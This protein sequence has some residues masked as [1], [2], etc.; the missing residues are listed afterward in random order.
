MKH[1]VMNG[2]L[3]PVSGWFKNLKNAAT[4]CIETMQQDRVWFVEDEN[5]G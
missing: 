1:R 5:T 2:K 4:Q 3:H